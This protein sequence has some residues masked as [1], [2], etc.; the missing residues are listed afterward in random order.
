[1][2]APAGAGSVTPARVADREGTPVAGVVG[3]GTGRARGLRFAAALGFVL[4]AAMLPL[5][6]APMTIAGGLCVTLA[7]AAGIAGRRA[8]WSRTPLERPAL[9]WLAAL[10]LATLFA[11]DRS[12]TEPAR[13]PRCWPPGARLR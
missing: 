3:G 11:A 7:L 4:Y 10:V 6:M 1:V 5:A 12:A 13:S 9:V 8:P 2:T